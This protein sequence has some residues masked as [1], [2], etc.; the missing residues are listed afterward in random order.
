MIMRVLFIIALLGIII[1]YIDLYFEERLYKTTTLQDNKIYLY[2]CFIIL[3][4]L[5]L[6]N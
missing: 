4:L 5:Y 3:T 6:I 2:M 1:V